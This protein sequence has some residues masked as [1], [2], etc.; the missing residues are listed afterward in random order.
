MN[1]DKKELCYLAQTLCCLLREVKFG[2]TENSLMS[3]GVRKKMYQI[4]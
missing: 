4:K 3:L 2:V 1:C